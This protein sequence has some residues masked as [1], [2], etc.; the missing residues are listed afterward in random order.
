MNRN[1][2]FDEFEEALKNQPADERRRAVDYYTELYEDKSERYIPE[3][4]ILRE[5]GDPL[6]AADRI[7]NENR[8]DDEKDEPL[9]FSSGNDEQKKGNRHHGGDCDEDDYHK[10][11]KFLRVV[12]T[13]CPLLSIL[14]FLLWGFLANRWGTAWMVF[15][16]IP[17][18]TSLARAVIKGKPN[19]FAYPVYVTLIFL[20]LGMYFSLWHPSWVV[21]IT[22]PAYYIIADAIKGG[23]SKTKSGAR[24]FPVVGSLMALIAMAIPVVILILSLVH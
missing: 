21:F 8:H 17:I 12:D 23:K 22:I 14:A 24:R 10:R 7:I 3:S 1:Q 9:E 6:A 13:L 15:L 16:L 11:S 5:F 19:R 20:M 4:D 2:W 18:C